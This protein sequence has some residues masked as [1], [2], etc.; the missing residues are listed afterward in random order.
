[1][2]PMRVSRNSINLDID[3]D[4]D[5]SINADYDKF[6][7]SS[8]N[9]SEC[10]STYFSDILKTVASN[11]EKHD[12]DKLIENV[13]T[14][15]YE[16]PAEISDCLSFICS[17]PD[18]RVTPENNWRCLTLS[19]ASEPPLARHKSSLDGFGHDSSP[20]KNSRLSACE[21]QTSHTSSHQLFQNVDLDDLKPKK[22]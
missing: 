19:S 8:A 2:P 13:N 16:N 1:M 5:N 20:K 7:D 11:S 18:K 4:E 14:K 21:F 22:R 17:H 9:I 3:D 15:S 6:P 12:K 10:D